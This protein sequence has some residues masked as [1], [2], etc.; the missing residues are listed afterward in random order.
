MLE[1]LQFIFS[2]FWIFL[3][4]MILWTTTVSVIAKLIFVLYNRTWRHWNI[5]K[6]G[7]PPIYCDADGDARAVQKLSEK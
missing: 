2:G 5:R 7:Y 1:I 3:G 6:L 4:F